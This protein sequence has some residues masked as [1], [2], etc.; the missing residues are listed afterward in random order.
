LREGLLTVTAAVYSFQPYFIHF[1]ESDVV[2]FQTVESSDG[3]NARGNFIGYIG[4]VVRPLLDWTVDHEA[5]RTDS[6]APR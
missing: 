2:S 1:K 6:R 4:G 3:I 5:I